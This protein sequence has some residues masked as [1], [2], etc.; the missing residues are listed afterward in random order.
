MNNSSTKKINV[1]RAPFSGE[2]AQR[3]EKYISF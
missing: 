2:D 1:L 3:A